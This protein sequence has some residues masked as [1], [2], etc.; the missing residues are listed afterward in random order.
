MYIAKSKAPVEEALHAI[1]W[2]Q[3]AG[4]G[5]P[6]ASAHGGCIR[7]D[8]HAVPPCYICTFTMVDEDHAVLY[9]E[10]TED[11]HNKDVFIVNIPQWV[12]DSG[13]VSHPIIFCVDLLTTPAGKQLKELEDLELKRLAMHVPAG[14]S[15]QQQSR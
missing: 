2:V 10:H 6:Q 14:Y 11:G 8:S 4:S 9:R 3:H 5:Q 1:S 13:L 15:V 12:C 7:S